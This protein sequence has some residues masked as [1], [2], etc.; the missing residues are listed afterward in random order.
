MRIIRHIFIIGTAVIV[1]LGLPLLLSGYF[2]NSGRKVDAV[3]SASVII[4]EP[5]GN[6]YV[7][8]NKNRHTDVKKLQSWID[9]FNG[10]E[11]SFIFEDISCLVPD[12]DSQGLLM[13]QSFQ[14]RLPEH[15]M[16]V[17][18]EDGILMLSKAEYGRFDMIIMSKEFADL[19]KAQSL[20]EHE[21]NEMLFL[22]S[23]KDLL[24]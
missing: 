12:G 20:G 22:E 9:F 8:I 19:Y 17:R 15:Q 16:S 13:A 4:E 21:E 23:S 11:V 18:Q 14:S 24:P 1:I 2:T 6:Y 3:S 5:S 10:E 7:F